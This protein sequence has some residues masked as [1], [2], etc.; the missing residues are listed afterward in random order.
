MLRQFG[1]NRLWRLYAGYFFDAVSANALVPLMALC[2]AA[3][4]VEPA[5][6]GAVAAVLPLAY[7]AA[8]MVTG[9][10]VGHFGGRAVYGAALVLGIIAAVSF[11]LVTS[12]V[13]WAWFGAL[14]GFAGGMRYIIAESLVPAFAPAEARGRA[15]ATFQSIVGAAMFV[16]SGLLMTVQLSPALPFLLAAALLVVAMG[17]LWT[18]EMPVADAPVRTRNRWRVIGQVGP[19]VLIAAFLSGLFEAGTSTA[20]PM[21]G[22]V[23]G[24]SATLAAALVTMIGLGSFFQYPFGMLADRFPLPRVIVG[25]AIITVF[26]ALLLPLAHTT[27][28][29]LW[30]LSFLW[31]S[32]GGGL[33]TLASIQLGGTFRGPQ[34]VSASSVAQFAY[35]I[36]SVV[37]PALGGVALD[38]S[39]DFGVAAIFAGVGMIGLAGMLLLTRRESYG[40][41]QHRL[42][43]VEV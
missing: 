30:G 17:L 38:I 29:L 7:I 34:L 23:T 32:L 21:Y 40:K 13:A 28:L 33:Y 35:T 4:N 39:P 43:V 5:M 37:G 1:R 26:G 27:P 22:V 12:L 14:A 9:R 25:T 31:G 2:M 41:V 16:S 15:M 24:L 19:L 3:R 6:I 20:L 36:G 8:L 11:T 10:L 18:L 42:K